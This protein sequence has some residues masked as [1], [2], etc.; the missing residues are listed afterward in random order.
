MS[1]HYYILCKT[2]NSEHRFQE[3]NHQLPLIRGLIQYRHLIA[4]L[5][6]VV[7]DPRMNGNFHAQ[8]SYHGDWIDIRWFAEHE[9]HELVAIDEY[10]RVYPPGRCRSCDQESEDLGV[11]TYS[12]S[13]DHAL[14]CKSCLKTAPWWEKQ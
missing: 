1:C 11:V 14:V 10:G 6:P 9:L 12:Q 7:N 3:S 2:C 4:N 8:I 13:L 5:K